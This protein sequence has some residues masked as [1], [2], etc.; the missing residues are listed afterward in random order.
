MVE[1]DI[2]GGRKLLEELARVHFP[3]ELAFWRQDDESK[4]WHLVLAVP[5]VEATGSAPEYAKLHEILDRLDLPINL[6]DL[7]VISASD[8][9]AVLVSR[10]SHVSDLKQGLRL[11]ETS[12]GPYHFDGLY[13]YEPI[14][15]TAQA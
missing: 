13:I 14:E 8:Q 7:S 5:G 15:A 9:Q 12:V 2:P 6:W 3:F 4:I 10:L 1:L 11:G